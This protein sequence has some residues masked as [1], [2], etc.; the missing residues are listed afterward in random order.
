M[1]SI[2]IHEALSKANQIEKTL[3][4]KRNAYTSISVRGSIMYFVIAQLSS[5]DPMYQNSLVYVK[6]LFN[7]TIVKMLL[8]IEEQKT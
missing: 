1:K 8:K 3:T 7:E 6:K 2:E 4:V 5:I